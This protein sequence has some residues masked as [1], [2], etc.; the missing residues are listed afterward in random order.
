MSA[1][2]AMPRNGPAS[3]AQYHLS[4]RKGRIARPASPELA[5]IT[6]TDRVGTT[7]LM[8]LS[9]VPVARR[10]AYQP[11]N[12]TASDATAATRACVARLVGSSSQSSAEGGEKGLVTAVD[13]GLTIEYCGLP[14]WRRLACV[15]PSKGAAA[16]ARGVYAAAPTNC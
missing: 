5:K 7:Q 1:A 13:E 2:T 10:I 4:C 9:E 15:H 11:H 3:A 16:K 12:R 8:E 6:A 14:G